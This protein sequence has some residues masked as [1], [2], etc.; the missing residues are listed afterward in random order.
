MKAEIETSTDII[1]Y[2]RKQLDDAEAKA[3]KSVEGLKSE[4]T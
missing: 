3:A 1:L 2:A 4:V